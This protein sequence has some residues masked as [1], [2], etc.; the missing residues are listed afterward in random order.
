MDLLGSSMERRP[1]YAPAAK[2]RASA[3]D[4]MSKNNTKKNKILPTLERVPYVAG[5][6]SISTIPSPPH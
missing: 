4:E 5:H 2:N 6:F 3:R 1:L